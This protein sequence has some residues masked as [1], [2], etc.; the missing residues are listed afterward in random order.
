[1]RGLARAALLVT[2][3]LLL[4]VSVYAGLIEVGLV[5]SPLA[6]VA[7]GDLELAPA[8]ATACACSSSGTA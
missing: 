1:M 7:A 4:G 3:G 6:P 5:R 8:A 2:A